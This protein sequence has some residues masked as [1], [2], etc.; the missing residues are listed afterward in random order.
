MGLFSEIADVRC[1]LKQS[2]VH[3]SYFRSWTFQSQQKDKKQLKA[4][5]L[6]H[7]I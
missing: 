6:L 7:I 5:A 1:I 4:V 3:S 2:P